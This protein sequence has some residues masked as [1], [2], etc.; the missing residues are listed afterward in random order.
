MNYL[1]TFLPYLFGNKIGKSLEISLPDNLNWSALSFEETLMFKSLSN[2]LDDHVKN[3]DLNCLK[4]N[5]IFHLFN[6]L[7]LINADFVKKII[8]HFPIE[9]AL[10]DSAKKSSAIKI[11]ELQELLDLKNNVMTIYA[12]LPSDRSQKGKIVVKSL[13]GAFVKDEKGNIWSIPV[14][15][16]SGRGLSFSHSNGCT[17]MGIFTIDSVMPKADKNYEF[18]DFRRLIVN[19]INESPD[20]SNLKKYLPKSHLLLS[21]WKQSLVARNLG[22]SLLRI[23]GTGRKNHNLFSSFFPLVPTSGCLATNEA[24]LLGFYKA[25]DQRLLLDVIMKAQALS[26]CFENELKI[27]GLLYVVEFDDNLNSLVF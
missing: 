11:S 26:P 16:L 8:S 13:D 21:W 6:F 17:P 15:G 3:L 10:F 14:I 9:Y 19:F 25:Q 22:R 4:K 12:L 2:N 5:E 7:S 24:K 23:H 1:K 18:G 27:H 20:E